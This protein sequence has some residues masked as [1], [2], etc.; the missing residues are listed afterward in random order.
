MPMQIIPRQIFPHK[1]G[2]GSV[3]YRLLMSI[4]Q[5]LLWSLLLTCEVLLA[6]LVPSVGAVRIGWTFI[7]TTNTVPGIVL[8]P[9]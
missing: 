5:F 7:E 9:G 3:L 1:H 8:Q 6:P 4:F 2:H